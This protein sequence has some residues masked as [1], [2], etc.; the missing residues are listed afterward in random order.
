VR[1]SVLRILTEGGYRVE[2]AETPARALELCAEPGREVDV[3]LTDVVMP[4]MVGAELVER[5][6]RIRP[7]LG[8]IFM[9]GYS[10]DVKIRHGVNGDWPCLNKPFTPAE[11]LRCVGKIAQRASAG[12]SEIA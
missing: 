5:I 3:V 12:R 10:D 7:G 1:R 4:S 11:L 9:S 8:V 6:Q 2:E